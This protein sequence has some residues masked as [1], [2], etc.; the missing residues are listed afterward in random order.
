SEAGAETQ[1]PRRLAVLGEV[2]GPKLVAQPVDAVPRPTPAGARLAFGIARGTKIGLA[3]L[4]VMS[5]DR[6][7]Q[8]DYHVGNDPTRSGQASEGISR[9]PQIVAEIADR[10]TDEGRRAG[11][12]TGA[13]RGQR[14]LQRLK[15]VAAPGQSFPTGHKLHLLARAAQHRGRLAAKVREISL[16]G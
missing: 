11:R 3:G 4:V 15:R 8:T 1:Q 9:T 14:V 6:I 10:A 16:T 2:D 13:K 7:I 12:R 5:D